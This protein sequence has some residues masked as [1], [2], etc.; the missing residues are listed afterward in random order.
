MEHAGEDVIRL[1]ARTIARIVVQTASFKRQCNGAS[2]ADSSPKSPTKS[3]KSPKSQTKRRSKDSES[4]L[5]IHT[6]L[7]DDILNRI[8]DCLI[9][10]KSG[11][12]PLWIDGRHLELT[13]VGNVIA[14]GLVGS[15][16]LSGG[17]VLKTVRE[18]LQNHRI[19]SQ[20]ES[21]V[22]D[23][24]LVVLC[25]T[26]MDTDEDKS[27]TAGQR[28]ADIDT[29]REK[30]LT[31]L[32]EPFLSDHEPAIMKLITIS[33]DTR[34]AGGR[35]RTHRNQKKHRITRRQHNRARK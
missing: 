29:K 4:A 27:K 24:M 9:R 6:L 1:L 3:P 31:S 7:S 32:L 10:Y 15:E 5:T 11:I 33:A 14:T 23:D 30:L 13:K 28:S 18:A 34:K 19:K 8:I 16:W 20:L 12:Y 17:F 21:A 25:G 2:R 35:R 26:A 22:N